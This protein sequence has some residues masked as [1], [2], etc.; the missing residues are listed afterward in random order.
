MRK[1]I[2][3]LFVGLI[4]FY[5]LWIVRPLF[6]GQLTGTFQS[7][8]IPPEY[9]KLASFLTE[10]VTF[11]RTLWVPTTERYG[12]FSFIHPAISSYDLFQTTSISATLQVLSKSNAETMLS[13]ES[14]K[15][16]IVPDDSGKE[17]FLKDRKY[18]ASQY[19]FTI[20]SLQKIAW[21]HEVPGFGNIRV[22]ALA[23]TKDNF[24]IDSLHA[25]VNY[26]TINPTEYIVYVKDVK[27]GDMLIFTDA[28]D[29]GWV[30]KSNSQIASAKPFAKGINSFIL[31]KSGDYTVRV[32][33]KGQQW[34][35][36]GLW[37][38]GVSLVI[39]L[40]LL[41]WSWTKLKQ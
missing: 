39:L 9:T 33:F 16:I 17:I 38:S 6:L 41:I 32:S 22:F 2:A 12:F 8:S 3:R 20:K 30:L 28:Y 29:S 25:A 13:Q 36:I 31:P 24:W 19:V 34:V 1:I 14:I 35:V 10:D 27:K 15:Y 4:F 5:L 18:D 23:N 21:L 11:S 37:I 26:R 40:D 7:H